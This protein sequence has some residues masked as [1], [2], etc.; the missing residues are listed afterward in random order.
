M[1]LTFS[2]LARSWEASGK[3]TAVFKIVELEV[4]GRVWVRRLDGLFGRLASLPGV[5]PFGLRRNQSSIFLCAA[6]AP[7]AAA[8]FGRQPDSSLASG[9]HADAGFVVAFIVNFAFRATLMS[10]QDGIDFCSE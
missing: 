6:I 2:M 3:Q 9:H 5:P 1:G 10:K 8:P 7:A 4:L